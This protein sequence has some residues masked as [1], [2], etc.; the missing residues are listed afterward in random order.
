LER[1]SSNS[2]ADLATSFFSTSLPLV[3]CLGLLGVLLTSCLDLAVNVTFRTATTG[4]VQVDA[5]AHRM[6]QGLPVTEG[7]DRVPFPSTRAE[8]L[9]VVG[10]VPGVTLAAWTGAD[11][12]LGFRTRTVLE[13]SNARAL[14]GLFIVFK[15]KLTLLQDTQGKWTLTFAPLVPRV[16][17]ADPDTRRLWAA[18]WG[19]VIWTFGFTPP[20]QKRTE[21]TVSLAALAAAQPPADW[22]L[23]W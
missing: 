12:D 2:R 16:T 4:Q 21:R 9:T 8:W 18:L 7:T 17:G 13:F 19:Q 22:T 11:E 20:G 15:Q 23:S 5:L 14:E 10:Q 3:L 6:A 1:P